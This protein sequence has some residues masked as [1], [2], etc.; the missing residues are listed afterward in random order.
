M[1]RCF[2]R[3]FAEFASTLRDADVEIAEL[4]EWKRTGRQCNAL[5]LAQQ[6]RLEMEKLPKMLSTATLQCR[7]GGQQPCRHG[8]AKAQVARHW[9]GNGSARPP[10][11]QRQLLHHMSSPRG[12]KA[13]GKTRSPCNIAGAARG[14]LKLR[15]MCA[16][17]RIWTNVEDLNGME[18]S[19][20][21]RMARKERPDLRRRLRARGHFVL[22][23][24]TNLKKS[25]RHVMN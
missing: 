25:L 23:P 2:V 7:C 11:Q 21:V 20:A 10:L 14:F 6:H 8:Q 18:I 9:C 3:W 5:D 13:M 15:A 19:G 4:E 17:A 22:R 1:L 24:D 16:P 12:P